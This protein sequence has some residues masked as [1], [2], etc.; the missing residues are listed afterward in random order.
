MFR[1]RESNPGLLGES[2]L[3]YPRPCRI[4]YVMNEKASENSTC[5]MSLLKKILLNGRFA[6]NVNYIVKL[7]FFWPVMPPYLIK[8]V[9]LGDI[10]FFFVQR[11]H[12][13]TEGQTIKEE[14][15][16]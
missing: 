1:H 11:F 2:Q 9:A 10:I 3:S 7:L 14:Q 16:R 4:T 15:R 5:H 12:L 6:S 13:G 8:K